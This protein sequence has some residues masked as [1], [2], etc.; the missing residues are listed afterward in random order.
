VDPSV[1]ERDD[2][3]ALGNTRRVA[4]DVTTADVIRALTDGDVAAARVMLGRP[5]E[6]EGVLRATDPRGQLT[7][8][9][10]AADI[11]VPAVGA[12]AARVRLAGAW[13]A[14]AVSVV[15][16]G[17]GR[18]LDVRLARLADPPREP[19]VVGLVAPLGGTDGADLLAGWL[20]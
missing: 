13:E 18:R 9:V 1:L 2:V 6:L 7:L 10:S 3:R 15:A 11:V 16:S 5:P 8:V 4:N 20:G 19:V 12:Y 14:A 17:A